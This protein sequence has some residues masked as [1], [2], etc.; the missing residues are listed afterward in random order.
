MKAVTKELLKAIPAHFKKPIE[1]ENEK[2]D[3]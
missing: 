3:N 1:K 2:T